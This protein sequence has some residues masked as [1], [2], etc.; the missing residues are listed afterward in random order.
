VRH[1]KVASLRIK[2]GPASESE[3]QDILQK[4]FQQEPQ[5]EINATAS[6]RDGKSIDIVV[7]KEIQG[8][9]VS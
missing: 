2:N 3:W 1:D 9:T 5:P 7:R 4:L 8:I 6:V